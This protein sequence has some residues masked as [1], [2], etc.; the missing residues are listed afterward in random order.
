MNKDQHRWAKTAASLCAE[1]SAEDGVEPRFLTAKQSRK[2]SSSKELQLGKEAARILS[3]VLAGETDNP[4]L[5]DLVVLSALPEGNG[6]HLCVMV[7]HYATD[8]P[9]E[10]AQV[11]EALSRAQGLFRTVLAQSIN[12]KRVPVLTFRYVGALSKEIS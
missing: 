11:L 6:Q 10:E 5:R 12:R 7:G 8:N 3:L 9:F 1:I 4:L 2:K